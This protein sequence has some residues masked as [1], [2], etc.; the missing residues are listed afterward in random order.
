MESGRAVML[1]GVMAVVRAVMLAAEAV[2]VMAVALA[3]C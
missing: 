2:G 3:N 1:A